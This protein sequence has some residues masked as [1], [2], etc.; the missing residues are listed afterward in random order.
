MHCHEFEDRLNAALDE[1]RN[2]E[3]DFKLARHALECPPCHQLLDGHQALLTALQ[4]LPPPGL[5]SHFAQR[6]VAASVVAAEP[7]IAARTANRGWLAVGT[8][9]ASAA[10]I[11]IAVSLVW[12]A[13]RSTPEIG[14]LPDSHGG[15][16]EF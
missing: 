7:S 4:Q 15:A 3:A 8:L 13:R 12:I 6:V 10:A 11:L 9:L 5:S 16:A 2:P 1:R 14:N